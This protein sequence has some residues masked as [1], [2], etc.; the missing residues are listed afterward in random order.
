MDSLEKNIRYF[1]R[2][3][4]ILASLSVS[5]GT[6]GES[7]THRDG[8]AREG[9]PV[10]EHTIYDLASVSKLFLCVA[11]M[12]LQEAGRLHLSDPVRKY[13][14]QFLYLDGIT[15][16]DLMAF[17]VCLTTPVRID[18]CESREEALSA[19]F[20]CRPSP[21]SGVRVYSDI[22]AM[23]LKYAVE[24]A[25]DTDLFSLIRSQ[26][27][28]PLGMEHTYAKVP[29]L[30]LCADYSGERRLE[31]GRFTVR[32]GPAPGTPHD[33]KAAALSPFGDDLCGHAGLFST[34]GDM[35]RFCRGLLSG[36]LLSPA[37][38]RE[39]SVNRTGC[40]LGDGR[41]RQ[42]L[43]YLCYLKHP[44]QY[45][46]EIPAYMGHSAFGIG[47]FTGNHLSVDPEKGI[48][49]LFLGNRCRSRLTV[50]LPE[51]GKSRTDYGLAENGEGIYS[52][53]YSSVDWVHRKDA[54]LH[55]P[56]AKW[57]SHDSSRA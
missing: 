9:V 11:L 1:T 42:H 47:G 29:D 34:E 8:Y 40:V 16:H 21:I 17:Q 13:A 44:N 30:S 31:N 52:G 39:I 51:A 37:S 38:L 24:S 55:D 57:F 12:Q 26:I 36:A 4:H 18:R 27:L 2:E 5:F 28:R 46:S 41:I 7:H 25:A 6:L 54:L 43:G 35:I 53:V 45:D 19:L 33:P 15:L 20:G 32:T 56:I 3:S 22:P 23:V 10:T 14:P 49:A 50:L 48:F